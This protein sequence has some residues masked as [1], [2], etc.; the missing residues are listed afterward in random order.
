MSKK[1]EIAIEFTIDV[2]KL[3]AAISKANKES[4]KNIEES[5]K[6]TSETAKTE[7][8]T[9]P[10]SKTKGK[11]KAKSE[12]VT[13]L[14]DTTINKLITAMQDTFK[15]DKFTEDAFAVPAKMIEDAMGKFEKQLDEFQ[16]KEGKDYLHLL[17]ENIRSELEVTADGIQ[18][19]FEIL[20]GLKNITQASSAIQK[21]ISIEEKLNTA[22]AKNTVNE[23]VRET[24]NK[25]NKLLEKIYTELED[26][27][28][29]NEA[30]KDYSDILDSIKEI[31]GWTNDR[32]STIR[33]KQ[34][35]NFRTLMEAI[36]EIPTEAARVERVIQARKP[37]ARATVGQ[38]KQ[39]GEFLD[40]M[41][42]A[43]K[44]EVA[45]FGDAGDLIALAGDVETA[46][47]E[48]LRISKDA[49][50]R[51]KPIKKSDDAT[52]KAEVDLEWL[53]A[54]T[55]QILEDI[56]GVAD[57]VS[58]ITNDSL[59]DKLREI[60][61]TLQQELQNVLTKQKAM[62]ISIVKD[63]NENVGLNM[64][65]FFNDFVDG[66]IWDSFQ[67]Y[68]PIAAKG[69]GRRTPTP[70]VQK[71]ERAKKAKA[72]K[73][74]VPKELNKILDNFDFAL[75]SVMGN[76]GKSV[77]TKIFEMFEEMLSSIDSNKLNVEGVLTKTF[78]NMI[79]DKA[80]GNAQAQVQNITDI[81]RGAGKRTVKFTSVGKT[82]V[83][84]ELRTQFSGRLSD[85]LIKAS[86]GMKELNDSFD[87]LKL[88]EGQIHQTGSF[89]PTQKKSMA[90]V[91]DKM[92]VLIGIIGE[93]TATVT[94]AV[95]KAFETGS[96]FEIPAFLLT[97]PNTITD[98]RT[99]VNRLQTKINNTLK[100][101]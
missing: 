68:A 86:I 27:G 63:V 64:R 35:G 75:G 30:G 23:T 59:M 74:Q 51:V 52:V 71:K 94:A 3:A 60:E 12:V 58:R 40:E 77:N 54:D 96:E 78:A 18:K 90:E 98:L 99:T 10:K 42:T 14:D 6:E 95:T 82:P 57:D 55:N 9:V 47:N 80:G 38:V 89:T 33:D 85:D 72:I 24:V 48:F 100:G 83:K 1:E 81:L 43:L 69:G 2:D 65:T 44:S 15:V 73:T 67:K 84:K 66:A 93:H 45:K 28:I 37:K 61:N 13:G 26:T 17:K 4:L 20:G 88:N 19:I 36:K 7:T 29:I 21:L 101:L 91:E 79:A 32:T 5:I 39:A 49:K 16:K 34:V 22:T 76:V 87:A 50:L 92:D 8:K 25:Q 41:V 53:K 46:T 97:D 62:T 70:E 31:V 56:L 11:G